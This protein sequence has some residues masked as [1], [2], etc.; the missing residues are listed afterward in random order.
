MPHIHKSLTTLLLLT[1][2]IRL[3]IYRFAGFNVD[4]VG[5]LVSFLVKLLYCFFVCYLH[6]CELKL[7]EDKRLSLER[8]MVETQKKQSAFKKYKIMLRLLRAFKFNKLKARRPALRQR[9]SA[10]SSSSSSSDGQKKP[11][12]G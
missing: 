2:P 9:A 6:H 1:F 5:V 8:S 10:S 11:Q 7:V 4:S 12:N 3:T